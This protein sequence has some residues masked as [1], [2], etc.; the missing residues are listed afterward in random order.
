VQTIVPI[1]LELPGNPYAS[2]GTSCIGHGAESITIPDG[3]APGK[4]DY[5]NVGMDQSESLYLRA[6][7]AIDCDG[8]QCALLIVREVKTEIPAKNRL[9]ILCIA[10]SK[11]P[12][13]LVAITRTR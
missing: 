6:R 12:A 2:A 5:R 7:R 4:R 8:I 1:T 13:D 11:C 9:I 3:P 10:L